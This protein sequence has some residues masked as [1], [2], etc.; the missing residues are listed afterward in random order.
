MFRLLHT[1][2]NQRQLVRAFVVRDIKSRYV[3]SSMG[4]FWSVV[5]PFL[6]LFV[7]MVVFSLFMN[8]RWTDKSGPRDTA[9]FMLVGILSW[10]AFAETLSRATNCLVENANLI[11]KVVFPSEILP[12]FLTI[13]SLV[14][15]LIGMPI[16]I[17]GTYFFTGQ[18][19]TAAYA[20][21]PVLIV[22]QGV[23]TVGV[24]YFLSTLNLFLRDTY[25]LV[26]VLILMWM[27]G[28]PIFYPEHLVRDAVVPLPGTGTAVERWVAVEGPRMRV[29]MPSTARFEIDG[30][31]D[32]RPRWELESGDEGASPEIRRFLTPKRADELPPG[33]VPDA[34]PPADLGAYVVLGSVLH[35]RKIVEESRLL[36]LR[37]LLEINPMYWLINSYRN[38][39]MFGQWPQWT[40]M[41][42]LFVVAF[43]ALALGARFFAKHKRRFPD[44]L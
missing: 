30:V 9:I 41:A 36:P 25:H 34:S 7:F 32:P 4:F 26:G 17:A 29:P 40:L 10:H 18:A 31:G 28:T 27:F 33:T 14:N 1:L 13:S 11:Q 15:M 42:R 35:E 16:A 6:Y 39:I 37:F 8:T 5:V 2:W 24:G 20:V 21:L 23:F 38:V 44:L 43:V 3:G 19:P 22:L 12:A